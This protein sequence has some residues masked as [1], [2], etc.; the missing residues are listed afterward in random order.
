[1]NSK[2]V[3]RIHTNSSQT[4]PEAEEAGILPNSFHEA[5]IILISKLDKNGT[6]KE[7]C[8]PI[9]LINTDAKIFNKI[10]ANIKQYIKGTTYNHQVGFFSKDERII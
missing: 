7:N 10:L 2:Y 4:L 8:R 3:E 5:R 1:M 9:S 6:R